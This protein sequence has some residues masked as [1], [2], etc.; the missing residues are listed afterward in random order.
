VRLSRH[1]VGTAVIFFS[2][3]F[4]FLCC[5]LRCIIVRP[6]VLC[7]R[8]LQCV[9]GCCSVLQWGDSSPSV[10]RRVYLGTCWVARCGV[11]QCA[12]VYLS[13]SQCVAVCCSELQCVAVCC[14]VSTMALAVWRVSVC[15]S[16]S[17]CV[18]V[19]E[20][21]GGV[22]TTAELCVTGAVCCS[23][24]QCVA[25]AECLLCVYHGTCCVARCN[26]LQCVSVHEF[27]YVCPR[28]HVLCGVGAM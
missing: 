12:A 22:S 17:Q 8:V 11:L 28:R 23:V 1:F 2:Y 16:M 18:S 14:S 9:A 7:G 24:M 27:V 26:V 20:C 15:C 13:V 25:D 5:W 3:L 10:S 6:R 21:V 19:Y 4:I